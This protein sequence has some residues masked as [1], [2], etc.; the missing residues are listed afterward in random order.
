MEFPIIIF[1]KAY[2][3]DMIE[4]IERMKERGTISAADLELC[5]LQILLKKAVKHIQEKSIKNSDLKL[6][7]RENAS[8]GCLKGLLIHMEFYPAMVFTSSALKN[9]LTWPIL[10]L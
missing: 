10:F 4:H 9:I 7:L 6:R 3:K 8:N 2:H 1:D 5:L